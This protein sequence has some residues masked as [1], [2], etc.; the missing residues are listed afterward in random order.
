MA[1]ELLDASLLKDSALDSMLLD[2]T[3]LDKSLLEESAKL[4]EESPSGSFD[5]ETESLQPNNMDRLNSTANNDAFF[6]NPPFSVYWQIRTF[7]RSCFCHT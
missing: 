4:L 2:E 3:S 5:E 1:T 7:C 6:I